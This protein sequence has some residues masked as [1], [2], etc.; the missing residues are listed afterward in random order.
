MTDA[1]GVREALAQLR[2]AATTYEDTKAAHEDARDQAAEA[3]VAALRAG[4]TPTE[5]TRDSPFTDAYVR[6][7]AREA[8][9]APSRPGIKPKPKPM[10]R[11]RNNV[12]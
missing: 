3:V 6:K 11:P 8:G 5:V 7:I 12:K 9:I 1:D 4:A 10:P 2:T